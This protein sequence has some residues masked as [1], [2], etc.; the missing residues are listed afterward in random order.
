[1]GGPGDRGIFTTQLANGL[2]VVVVEDHAAPVVQTAIWYHFG[3]LDETPGKTGLAHAL[4]HMMFRGSEHISAG[5]LDD[6]V[7]RLGAQMNAE[8]SYDAT[9]FYFVMP[10]D[11]LNVGL[12]I[13]SDRLQHLLLQQSQWQIERGAVLNELEGD[14]SSPFYSLLSAVRA[15]A[16]PGEPNGRTPIGKRADIERA[17]AADIG[18]YYHEWY[19]PNNATLVVAGDVDHS[20]VFSSAKRYF[21]SIPSKT[22][23]AHRETHPTP[24]SRGAVVESS[25]PFPFEVLDLAYAVPGDTEPGEPAVSTLATL[26]PDQLSPFYQALVQS[27]VALAIEADSDTQLKGGLLNVFIVLNPGHT[28]AEA[29]TIFQS[30]LDHLLQS[31]FSDDLVT[32]AKRLTISERLYAADSISGI[33]DLAGYTYGIV[34]EKVNDEDTRLAALTSA[35]LLA[36]AKKY[37]STPTVVG[38]LRS[39]ASQ[40]QGSSQKSDAAASDDFS[41]RVPNGPIVEPAEIREALRTPTT[42]RSKLNPT[43]FT[44][45]NG[46]RVI[47]QEKHDRPTFV[48]RGDIDSSPAFAPP[49]KEG[50][51]R[52]ASSVA[53]YGSANYPFAQRR[54]AIDDLGAMVN[55][56]QEFSARGLA[57]DFSTIVGIVADAQEHPTFA[58]PWFSLER[59]QLANSLQSEDTISGVIVERAYLGLLAST[60][61]PSLRHASSGSVS[62]ITREDLASFAKIVLAPG[63]HDDRRRG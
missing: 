21:G 32:A 27:N 18:T 53:D 36:T 41:K 4:E 54:K 57:K 5:G 17:T 20:T 2:K 56:G 28:S 29:Q 63:S 45:P 1:M 34:G 42:E 59:D 16:Y 49:G 7:A 43:Q 13:E 62:S 46:I 15:A 14:E 50:I 48:L 33:G 31:G 55:S 44:L 24:A 25:M 47:V 52:L 6:I 35:D 26:I 61:D 30:T 40:P 3:S 9:H 23:P 39:N 58:D 10:A 51:I 22:L 37:L 60:G 12:A 19:A 11:K 38:H 8:T